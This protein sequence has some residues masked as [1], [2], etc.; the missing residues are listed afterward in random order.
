MPK[1]KHTQTDGEKA[2]KKKKTSKASQKATSATRRKP[3]AKAV[4]PRSRSTVSLSASRKRVTG[5][6]KDTVL[7]SET[8][9][10]LD[11]HKFELPEGS[12][13]DDSSFEDENLGELPESY[14]TRR[15]FLAARDPYWLFAYWDMNA[16][17]IREAASRAHDGKVFLRIFDDA[18]NQALQAEI[19][20]STRNY[21]FH[22]QR[23]NT[24][25]VAEIGYYRQGDQGFE[26]VSR[27]GYTATPRDAVSPNTHARFATIPF[28]Y[29]FRQ[30][31]EMIKHL[32]MGDEEL[33][34]AIA[35]LQEAGHPFPFR[36]KVR[37][38]EWTDEQEKALME[39]LG[40]DIFN[41]IWMGSFELTEWLRRRL[42][43]AGGSEQSSM[44]MSSWGGTVSSWAS[45]VGGASETLGQR[46]RGFWMN[47]NAELII[48]GAT[49]PGA[50][51]RIAGQPIDIRRDGSF[52]FHWSFPDGSYH[53]PVEATS[54][55]G[56]ETRS[57]LLS[58]LR[59]TAR[60]GEVTDHP[61]DPKFVQPVG[62]IG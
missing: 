3:V 54:P 53:I 18:G 26:V 62:R 22:A 19:F 7:L 49:D 15:L 33:A 37:S 35:R 40:D 11:A 52:S 21:Y 39:F 61:I 59:T 46:E 48:Y 56:V 6:K 24:T 58:F 1:T 25:F 10:D 12:H 57:A 45:A 41:R 17:Q 14:G 16:D 51:L 44:L 23:A 34:D 29:T 43:S 50:S 42:L 28:G 55:D 47:V 5:R 4:A 38:G 32:I 30:L 36:V 9:L 8:V 20:E 2:M 13:H 31:L 60:S 27:S